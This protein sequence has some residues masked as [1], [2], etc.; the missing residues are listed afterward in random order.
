MIPKIIHYCWFGGNSLPDEYKKYIDSWKKLC[1]DY[2]IKEWN[3]SNYDV[4]KNKYMFDAYNVKKWAFVP[5]YAR[6]DIIYEYGGFYLDTDVELVKSLDELIE[7]KGYLG[8][9][10]AEYVNGGLG[11]GAE[12]GNSLI[13]ELRDM[14]ENISFYNE[15]STLN[16]LPSPHYITNC[17]KKHGLKLNNKQQMIQDITIFPSDYFA[18][19]DYFTGKINLTDNTVSIHQFSAS[20]QSIWDHMILKIERCNNRNGIEFKIR[21]IISFPIRV[22]NKIDKSGF[23]KTAK[24]VMRKVAGNK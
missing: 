22:I 1:P 11:F 23:K 14:Y 2:E 8:F 17:L 21:R 4:S 15:D 13:K 24:F 10:T 9:E 7:L 3:E 18:A 19:K 16:L 5:D 12:K 20:W 6:F